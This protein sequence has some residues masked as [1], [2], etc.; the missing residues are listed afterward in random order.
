MTW[1]GEGRKYSNL[2]GHFIVKLRERDMICSFLSF[3]PILW[4]HIQEESLALFY[5]WIIKKVGLANGVGR[6]SLACSPARPSVHVGVGTEW[7]QIPASLL[8]VAGMRNRL[9]LQQKPVKDNRVSSFTGGVRA[10]Q[11]DTTGLIFNA[12]LWTR[13]AN[14]VFAVELLKYSPR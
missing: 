2:C 1:D 4:V 9:L 10:R 7:G 5:R 13:F 8:E 12:R 6:A 3:F 11:Q 14:T